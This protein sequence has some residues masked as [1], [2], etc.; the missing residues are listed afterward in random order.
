M[1]DT[2][3]I[4]ET[5]PATADPMPV[6]H[7]AAAAISAELTEDASVVLSDGITRHEPVPVV[8]VETEMLANA[9]GQMIDAVPMNITNL[10]VEE[11]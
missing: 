9:A 1:A 10:D 5:V 7:D 8:I 11:P 6:R 4:T 2:L 3:A